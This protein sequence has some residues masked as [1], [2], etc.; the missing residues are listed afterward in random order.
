ME[1][2]PAMLEKSQHD[3]KSPGQPFTPDTRTKQAE[4]AEEVRSVAEQYLRPV[5]LRLEQ[6]RS[7]Q[8]E[9]QSSQAPG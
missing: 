7:R 5:Y 6:E 9:I 4:A 8:L 1:Q 3:A 2:I